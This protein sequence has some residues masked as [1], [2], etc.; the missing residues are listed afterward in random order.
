M[1]ATF[2]QAAVL[3]AYGQV[4]DAI[5]DYAR[6][7]PRAQERSAARSMGLMHEMGI[8]SDEVYSL[9][10]SAVRLRNI[11]VHDRGVSV[12]EKQV[13]AYWE[14]C[15]VLA[16]RIRKALAAFI[17]AEDKEELVAGN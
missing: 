6:A 9:F 5:A 7:Y 3:I 1:A 10:R 11:V 15:A 12:T 14:T 17:A 4:E 13:I 8:I 16:D 2:P